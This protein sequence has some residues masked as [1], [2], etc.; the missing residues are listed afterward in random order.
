VKKIIGYTR[1]IVAALRFVKTP[2]SLDQVLVIAKDLNDPE[3]TGRMIQHF[4][5]L[6][7]TQQ[8]FET[9]PHLGRV[10]T[11]QLRG[12]PDGSFGREFIRFL[13]D[14]GLDAN[15]ISV[16]MSDTELNSD[17]QYMM[18]HFY[19][20]H[21]IWHVVTGFDSDLPGELGLQ[22]FYA[23]K[24]PS[25][26]PLLMISLGL[27]NSFIFRR[28]DKDKHFSAI[29]RGWTMGKNSQPFFGVD[30][31]SYWEMPLTDLRALL[32]ISA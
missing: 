9:Q 1:M 17:S 6:P 18:N 19:S 26:F 8:V 30:W 13:D 7:E 11:D 4:K 22:A 5:S 15:D 28:E 27:M 10:D 12:L 16:D 24:G 32:G 14:Q 25:R 23:S 29:A 3:E 20:T 31:K 2:E 21:D